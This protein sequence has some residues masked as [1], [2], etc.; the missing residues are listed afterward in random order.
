MIIAICDIRIFALTLVIIAS[1]I[2]DMVA[3]GPCPDSRDPGCC[4]QVVTFV[5]SATGQTVNKP[6]SFD[7]QLNQCAW[8]QGYPGWNS[9]PSYSNWW[10]A[11][12]GTV[13]VS[14]T[15]TI[16]TVTFSQSV[17]TPTTVA[18]QP[19]PTLISPIIVVS[20]TIAPTVVNTITSPPVTT[21][22]TV[23]MRA[24]LAP[25]GANGSGTLQKSANMGANESSSSSVSMQSLTSSCLAAMLIGML[26]LLWG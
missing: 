8:P 4:L 25:A 1:S 14:R 15:T 26:I 21:T 20:T 2:F 12:T 10:P 3:A 7:P 19:S 13:A 6:L 11:A 18:V 23:G 22:L 17:I 24:T 16:V 9:Y 5:D